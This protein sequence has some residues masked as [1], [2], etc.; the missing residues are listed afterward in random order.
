MVGAAKLHHS[1]WWTS[2]THGHEFIIA[3]ASK[4]LPSRC[5]QTSQFIF[6]HITKVPHLSSDHKFIPGKIRLNLIS[7]TINI[8]LGDNLVNI[9]ANTHSTWTELFKQLFSIK[10]R[11]AIFWDRTQDSAIPLKFWWRCWGSPKNS[12]QA[13][14]EHLDR[15]TTTAKT[16]RLC[17]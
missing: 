16:R 10:N 9:V 6:F 12:H 3:G 5:G 15:W 4:V 11:I 1:G 2:P 14:G 8:H 13:E 7:A 17:V